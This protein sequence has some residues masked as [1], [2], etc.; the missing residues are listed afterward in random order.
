L[1]QTQAAYAACLEFG[2]VTNLALSPSIQN[3]PAFLPIWQPPRAKR[4]RTTA[5][6]VA[7]IGRDKMWGYIADGKVKVVRHGPRKTLVVTES[8]LGLLASLTQ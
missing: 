7:G 5:C 1:R 3:L 2:T 4:R 8:L 6:E